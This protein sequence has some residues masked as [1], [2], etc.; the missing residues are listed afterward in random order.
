M[1]NTHS[2]IEKLRWIMQQLRDPHTGCPWDSKQTFASI[3]PYT[4]EEAYEVADAIES[5][6]MEE[7]K[8]ELA[9]LLFQV[10]FYAQLGQEQD[11]FDFESIAQHLI[12]KLIRRHPHVFDKKIQLSEDELNTQWNAIKSQERL[13]K[14]VVSDN[15]ILADIPSGMAPLIR[16]QKIQ[17]KCAKVGFDWK[18]LHGVVDKIYEE[19]DEVLV[20]VNAPQVKEDAIEEEIGDLLF[21][22]VNLARHTKV[23]AETALVKANRKFEQRFRLLEQHFFQK[24]QDI[25]SRSEQELEDV[26][27]QVKVQLKT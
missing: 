22:V 24:G 16:A 13:H 27:Q 3:V 26:W 4:I 18:E 7:V 17:Q 15:S 6:N 19:I 8:D 11:H 10:I 21:A 20:E 9:D 23:N 25:S 1:L 2:S 14:S 12:E 5:G